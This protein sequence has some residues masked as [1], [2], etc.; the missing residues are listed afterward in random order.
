MKPVV[1]AAQIGLTLASPRLAHAQV[2]SFSRVFVIVF[3]NHEYDGLIGNPSAPYINTLAG[4]HGNTSP[5]KSNTLVSR[6]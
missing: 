1:L 5:K 3:E 6:S 2:P 4:Q